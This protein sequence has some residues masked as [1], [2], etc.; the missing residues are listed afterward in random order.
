MFLAAPGDVVAHAAK[1]NIVIIWGDDI[2]QSNISAYSHGVMGYKTPNID[3]VARDSVGRGV[4]SDVQVV[5][6]RPSID[7][8]EAAADLL[9]HP[10]APRLELLLPR[11]LTVKSG[12]AATAG[13]KA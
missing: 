6:R 8:V 7:D 13:G 4:E 11:T 12:P 5:D 2:G 3:R 10:E 1:P 9:D